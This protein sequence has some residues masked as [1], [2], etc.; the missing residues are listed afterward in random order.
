MESPEGLKL[1][2]EELEKQKNFKT[3]ERELKYDALKEKK[4]LLEHRGYIQT[5]IH[6]AAEKLAKVNKLLQE[7]RYK[8]KRLRIGFTTRVIFFNINT[9]Y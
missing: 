8:N 5:F 7:K 2:L 1:Q 4:K 6:K 9:K 3:Q